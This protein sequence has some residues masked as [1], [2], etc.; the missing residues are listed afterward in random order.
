MSDAMLL[1]YELRGSRS[2]FPALSPTVT[3]IN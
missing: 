3:V 1:R 2:P